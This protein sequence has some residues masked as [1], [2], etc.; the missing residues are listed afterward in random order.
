MEDFDHQMRD[1]DRR[2]RNLDSRLDDLETEQ[3]SLSGK[4]GYTEDLDHELTSIRS[5]V[6]S[7]ED[8]LDELDEELRE[9]ASDTDRTVK[10]L[11]QQVR[12]LEGQL[13]A[14]GG[15]QPADLDA[16]T[17]DQRA[18]AR[19]ME[20]GWQA[21]STLLSDHE[22]HAFQQRLRYVHES[23][24]QYKTHRS[25][26]IKAAGTLATTRYGSTTHA[27][28]AKELREA[29]THEPRL[30]QDLH[31]QTGLAKEAEQALEA[32]TQTRTDK[33]AVMAAGTRAE[34]RLTLA[35]RGRLADA[36]SARALLPAWFVTVLGSAPPASGTGKWLEN[37]TQV[38]LY[39][40]TYGVTDQVVALG[41]KPNAD[42]RRREWYEQLV[43]DLRRW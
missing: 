34:R 35:L 27:Q 40:L 33:Q 37:A 36:V 28:A 15:A 10:R 29:L 8:K 1:T 43:K 6:R 25:A 19:T 16:Y 14:S 22:R 21:R 18:L 11:A 7:C 32:D 30:R 39:R 23:A 4:F 5:N 24:E 2:I 9:R 31:H 26:V 17:K 38:L 42:Q 20:S 3:Q 13:K 12:L 41:G